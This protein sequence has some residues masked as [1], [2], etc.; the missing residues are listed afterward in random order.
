M[1]CEDFDFYY[2]D[3]ELSWE[4]NEPNAYPSIVVPSGFCTDLTSIPQIFWSVLP[5]TGPYAWAA[6]VHDYLYW[7]QTTSRKA[8]DDIL[9]EAMMDNKVGALKRY[10]IYAAVRTP[11]G[12]SAWDANKT[13]RENGEKRLLKVFPP[14]GTE[15]SWSE[16]KKDPSH[17]EPA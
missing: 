2:T 14:K 6:I 4:P 11:A 17:F 7:T 10:A 13:A 3:G 16:W 12:Q 8:A 15:V 9:Y 1:P 5:K